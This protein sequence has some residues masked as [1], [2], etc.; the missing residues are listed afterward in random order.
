VMLPQDG[1]APDGPPPRWS[2]DFWVTDPDATAARA[3]DLG[4][5]VLA[6]PSDSLV[7]RSGVLADPQGASFTISQSPRG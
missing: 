6:P 3:T 1:Q 5:S 4:G 7:G 2:V